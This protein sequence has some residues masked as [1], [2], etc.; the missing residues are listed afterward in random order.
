MQKK[1]GII[2]SLVLLCAQVVIGQVPAEDKRYIEVTGRAELEI[3]PDEIIMDLILSERYDGRE[4]ITIEVQEQSLKT[5]LKE[6]GIDLSNL[7]LSYANAQY[8][9]GKKNIKDVLA[10]KHLKLKLSD[11]ESVARVFE[12]LDK[13]DFSNAYISSMG[14]K[15]MD[16][17]KQEMRIRAISAA[18]HKANYL[19]TTIGASLGK[20]IFVQ[21]EEEARRLPGQMNASMNAQYKQLVIDEDGIDKRTT[22][23]IQ[24]QSIKVQSSITVRFLIQ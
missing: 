6:I 13:L 18:K 17:L 9:R 16:S 8:V 2:V 15:R 19:L 20:P 23:A 4:K 24:L 3:A 10:S 7:S 21:E 12:Q 1:I 5:A 11:A 14:L 22:N